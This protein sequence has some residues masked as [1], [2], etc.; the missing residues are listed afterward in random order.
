[1]PLDPEAQLVL[2][3]ISPGAE[4]DPFTISPELF[5][6]GFAAMSS[7]EP[8]PEL[9]KV[10]DREIEG[11]AGPIPIRIYTPEGKTPKPAIVFFHGGGF[12]VGDL[13]SHDAT[14]RE[15]ASG[16]DC[17]VVAVDYRLAPEAKFP[18]AP[19]D[20]YSA[21]LWVSREA[22]S[23][24]I[25]ATRIAVAGDSAGGNLAAVVALMCRDRSGPSLAHQLLVYPVTDNCFDTPSYKANGSGYFLTENTMRWFWHHYLEKES[26]GDDFLASPLRA[27]DLSGL[28]PATVLTAEYDPLRDE[29]RAY[30]ARLEDAGVPT[31]YTDY[32]GVFHGFFGM[33]G[34]IPRARQAVDE[35]C[36]L[37]RSAFQV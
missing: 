15:L 25:D 23:L 12:V 8:G 27:T 13:E 29:G 3:T 33:A 20:C 37:L 28:P 36:A 21:T 22:G 31:I 10:E 6:A 7:Q 30:A 4:V 32:P 26:D 24:G 16:I 2:D 5:R 34:M 17:V 18:A 19:E 1:M 35:S 11:P 14:C 9:A